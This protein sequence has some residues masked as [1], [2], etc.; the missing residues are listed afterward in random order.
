MKKDIDDNGD[1]DDGDNG[2]D[3]YSD[4]AQFISSKILPYLV[5]NLKI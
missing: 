1:I 5:H 3:N 4:A 2:D